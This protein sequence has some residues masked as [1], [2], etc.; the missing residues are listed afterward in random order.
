MT[1]VR[2]RERAFWLAITKTAA[3]G[4]VSR[5]YMLTEMNVGSERVKTDCRNSLRSVYGGLLE[6]SNGVWF[7]QEVPFARMRLLRRSLRISFNGLGMMDEKRASQ[8]VGSIVDGPNSN[9]GT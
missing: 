7:L 2:D 1:L 8:E 4:G 9:L 6:V 3:G 5:I